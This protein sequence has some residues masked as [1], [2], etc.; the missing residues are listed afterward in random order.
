VTRRAGVYELNRMSEE[1]VFSGMGT[2]PAF[3]GRTDSTTETFADVVYYMLTAQVANM[4]RVVKRRQE[5][6][7]MLDLGSAGSTSIR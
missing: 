4:Q 2:Y 6:T 5:L 7:Y 3:H 1:Q